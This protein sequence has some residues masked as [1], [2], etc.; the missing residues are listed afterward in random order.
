MIGVSNSSSTSTVRTARLVR[1]GAKIRQHGRYEQ[2][3][4]GRASGRDLTVEVELERET[5]LHAGTLFGLFHKGCSNFDRPAS[6][7]RGA[8]ALPHSSPRLSSAPRAKR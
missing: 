6:R 4:G 8:G 5:P 1:P 7:V 2:S 3:E